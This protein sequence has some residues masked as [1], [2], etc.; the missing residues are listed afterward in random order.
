MTIK[1]ADRTTPA[2]TGIT[3]LG[4]GPVALA[5]ALFA[6]RSGT[7]LLAARPLAVQPAV[8]S[9]PAALLTL[10]LELGVVPAELDVQE[11]SRR[12]LVAWEHDEPEGRD[13][14][15]CAQLER[16]ALRGA[17]WRRVRE[18]PAI[19]V[20]AP[21][22]RD[23]GD[24][25]RLVDATGRRAVTTAGHLRPPRPWIAASATV[26]RGDADPTMRL[27][28][29]PTGYG[30]RLGSARWLTVG[31]VGP[32]PPPR[33]GHALR[34]RIE[35]L[36]TGWLTEGT[37]LDG[38]ATARR[39]ASLS[40]PVAADNPRVVPIGDAALARDALASQGTSIGISDARLLAEGYDIVGR[41]V[42]GRARHLRFLAT[43]L[44][45]CRYRDAPVWRAYREWLADQEWLAGGAVGSGG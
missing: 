22:A 25:T 45:S 5:C 34:N 14:P 35:G 1:L 9:V 6:A 26:A 36:G 19:R 11:L 15:A 39:V 37:A 42:D 7:V 23:S 16:S 17:L 29:G 38:V 18:C 44:H 4:S 20:V 2:S 10:L 31:H 24:A 27:A 8:E 43:A 13:S 40:V 28:A 41:I 3:V 32:G 30:Y 21:A 33:D 12:R